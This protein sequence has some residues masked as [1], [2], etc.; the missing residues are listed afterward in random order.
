M[1]RT[2]ADSSPVKMM[3]RKTVPV[4]YTSQGG[5]SAARSPA[6][7]STPQD[8]PSL[9]DDGPF[10]VDALDAVTVRSLT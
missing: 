4:R 3:S 7:G 5:S 2:G 6:S 9:R 10:P 8:G 1:P